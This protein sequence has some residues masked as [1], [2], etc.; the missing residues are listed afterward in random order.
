MAGRPPGGLRVLGSSSPAA[1]V[2]GA[3]LSTVEP[4]AANDTILIADRHL[5]ELPLEGLSVFEEG[6]D[7]V[8]RE[9]SL[10]M[11][12]SRLRREETGERCPGPQLI[13]KWD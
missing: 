2:A 9:F 8:A 3:A 10:Q 1:S 12:W 5:L 11:L 13:S 4:E 7:S 6:V